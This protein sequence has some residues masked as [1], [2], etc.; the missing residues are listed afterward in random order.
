MSPLVEVVP[1]LD[2]KIRE[3]CTKPYPLHPKGCPNFG[4]R[5]TCPPKAPFYSE[6]YNLFKPTYAVI[7][8]FDIA[9]HVAR[10]RRLHP[11]WSDR[12]LRC[13]LYWQGT[14]RKQLT[15]MVAEAMSDPRCCGYV[16]TA[17]PEAMGVDV[18]RTLLAAGVRLEWPPRKV[19]RQVVLLGAPRGLDT[20]KDK[21]YHNDIGSND[22]S[23]KRRRP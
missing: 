18:T 19:A 10:M 1:V 16:P 15:V 3:L 7:N 12:Q 9:G 6:V 8:E 4:K 5:N 13:V 22:R 23:Q 17:S 21:C 20:D 11:D 2:D 14:A